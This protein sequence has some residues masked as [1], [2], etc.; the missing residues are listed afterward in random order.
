MG[1]P[2]LPRQAFVLGAPSP[3]APA[4]L[5]PDKAAAPAQVRIPAGRLSGYCSHFGDWGARR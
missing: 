3:S 5:H 1:N 2:P 4:A